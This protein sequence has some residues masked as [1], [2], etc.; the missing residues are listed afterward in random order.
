MPKNRQYYDK[1]NIS[2]I[3]IDIYKLKIHI[4][5]CFFSD[6]KIQNVDCESKVHGNSAITIK[7]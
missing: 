3:L 7:I 5:V 6:Y 4:K 1:K 2:S